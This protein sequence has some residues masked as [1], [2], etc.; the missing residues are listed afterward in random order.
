M[1]NARNLRTLN[2]QET[3]VLNA[4][5]VRGMSVVTIADARGAFDGDEY[6]LARI[7]SRL[8][9]KRWLLRLER[10]KYLILPLTAGMEG[11]HTTHEFVL[12]SKLVQPYAIA[13]WSAS[14][15]YGFSEQVPQIVSVISPRRR[16]NVAVPVLG[17]RCRFIHATPEHFFGLIT[18]VIDDQPVVITDVHRTVIDCLNRTDLCGG[19]VE[20][21]KSVYHYAQHPHASPQCLTE[22]ASRLG[23]QTVFKRLGYLVQLWEIDARFPG[24]GWEESLTKWKAMLSAGFARLDPHLPKAG[25]YDERWKLQINVPPQQIK[26]RLTT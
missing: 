13:Y 16:R 3:H 21:A 19:I 14:H 11:A 17:F 23:N 22:Y 2:L 7:L 26:D 15:H 8:V 5:S 12:A 10:G 25:S 24:A 4:L 6:A 9:Q 20:A 18:V 1:I